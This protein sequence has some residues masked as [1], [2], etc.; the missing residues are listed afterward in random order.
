MADVGKLYDNFN[1]LSFLDLIAELRLETR[2]NLADN[3]CLGVLIE[4]CLVS[5]DVSGTNAVLNGKLN[6]SKL[7]TRFQ[8]CIAVLPYIIDSDLCAFK[9]W[10][11]VTQ[12]Q[13][14]MSVWYHDFVHVNPVEKVTCESPSERSESYA[15]RVNV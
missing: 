3:W 5:R 4:K 10:L 6:P 13:T 9:K 11:C 15:I 12:M 1:N 2:H 14:T 7:P 8:L